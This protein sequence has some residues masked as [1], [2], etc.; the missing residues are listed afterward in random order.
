MVASPTFDASVGELLL[1]AG[2]GA[3][4]IVAPPQV[5]AGEALTALL[6]NQRVG[7]A[8]LTPP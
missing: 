7:T 2:S 4:L 1:A 5:Y 8:I 3:A 6:H